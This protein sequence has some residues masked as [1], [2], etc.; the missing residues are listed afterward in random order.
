MWRTRHLGWF[1]NV[2]PASSSSYLL[3]D[4][5]RHL[6]ALRLPKGWRSSRS[7]QAVDPSPPR[8]GRVVPGEFQHRKQATVWYDCCQIHRFTESVNIVNKTVKFGKDYP[9]IHAFHYA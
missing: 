2:E 5:G 8:R 6:L 7:Y 4:Q 3:A 9:L 1:C